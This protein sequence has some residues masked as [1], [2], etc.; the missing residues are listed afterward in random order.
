MWPHLTKHPIKFSGEVAAVS[1]VNT[2][3]KLHRK[4]NTGV[5]T[6][7]TIT[8]SVVLGTEMVLVCCCLA[9]V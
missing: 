1:M 4:R 6:V 5:P 8:A 9:V 7:V 2:H 3:G